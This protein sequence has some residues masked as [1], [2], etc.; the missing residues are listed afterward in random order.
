MEPGKLCRMA[1]QG[2]GK[3]TARQ[4]QDPSPSAAPTGA[5]ISRPAKTKAPAPKVNPKHIAAARELRDRYLEYINGEAG[6]VLASGKYN[7]SRALEAR[8]V[9]QLDAA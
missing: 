2:S 4:Q 3:R 6:R 8:P 7:V 9:A 1:K 5:K